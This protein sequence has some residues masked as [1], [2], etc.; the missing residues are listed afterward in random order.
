M[1]TGYE[2]TEDGTLIVH[3]VLTD[4]VVPNAQKYIILGDICPLCRKL[5]VFRHAR[6]YRSD[7]A[8]QI[9]V[10]ERDI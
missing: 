2:E 6:N 3:A 8:Q 9:D 4:P 5:Y 10:V 1:S 7:L